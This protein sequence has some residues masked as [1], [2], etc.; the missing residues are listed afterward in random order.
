MIHARS[1]I[2]ATM[3]LPEHGDPFRLT[4]AALAASCAGCSIF[5]RKN[6]LSRKDLAGV[7]GFARLHRRRPLHQPRLD[8]MDAGVPHRLA[9]PAIRCTGVREFLDI[10]RARTVELMAIHVSHTGVTTMASR[11]SALTAICCGLMTKAASRRMPGSAVLRVALKVSGAVQ[12]AR[13]SPTADGGGYIY[14]FTG[15]HSLFVDTIAPCA[16]GVAHRAGACADGRERPSHF[17]ARRLM[18]HARARRNIR[19]IMARAATPTTC[20]DAWRT[21]A[22]SSQRRQLRCPTRSRVYSPFSTWSARPGW[23]CAA[24]PNSWN[25]SRPWNAMPSSRNDGKGG[26]GNVRFLGSPIRRSMASPIGIRA[27]PAWPTRGLARAARRPVQCAWPVDSSAAALPCKAAAPRRYLKDD[28]YWN[29]GL[30]VASAL[31]DEPYLGL[32]ANHQ[33]LILHSVYHRP[34]GWCPAQ[35]NPRCGAIIT[36]AKPPSICCGSWKAA[37][38]KFW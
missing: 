13:W 21:R 10:G 14:S 23:P 7:A 20:A 1:A 24:S 17:A 6:S 5:R 29:A 37:V 38:L 35:A 11:I 8:G 26:A 32:D 16:F 2:G 30:T 36:R 12:A 15:P 33:G 9:H 25:S 3:S 31:F 28:C 18:D 27:L 4:P 34:N 19:S 22:S